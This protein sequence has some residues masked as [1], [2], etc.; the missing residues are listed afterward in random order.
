MTYDVQTIDD[1][2]ASI[3]AIQCVVW[4][5]APHLPFYSAATVEQLLSDTLAVR[6]FTTLLRVLFGAAAVTPAGLGICAFI[7]VATAQRTR[8]IGLPL[9]MEAEPRN[10]VWM[11]VRGSVGLAGAGVAAGRLASLPFSQTSPACSTTAAVRRAN[12]GRGG[13][14]PALGGRGRRPVPGAAREPGGPL[15]ALRTE[16]KSPSAAPW[17]CRSPA[18]SGHPARLA[19]PSA[20]IGRAVTTHTGAS[21]GRPR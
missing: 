11:V 14:A 15:V 16:Q 13:P 1:P 17:S 3:P 5:A 8:A 6:R 20:A 10:V 18:F 21:P 19:P 7:A 9:A 4:H 12:T 2:A